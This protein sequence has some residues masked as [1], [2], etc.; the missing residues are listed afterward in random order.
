VRLTPAVAQRGIAVL[1]VL[2]LAVLIGLAI[3]SRRGGSS[4]P[5][6]LPARVGD[7]YQARAAPLS[8]DLEG[9]TTAC[10][11]QLT[12]RSMGIA[13]P[14]LPC[15]AKI[16]VGYRDEDVLTQVIATG[17]GPAGTRF[18]LTPALARSL[19]IERPVTIRWSYAR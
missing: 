19:G 1:A 18:G 7:W 11:V 17:P 13:D 5:S 16:F 10:G 8:D 2:L 3:A 15:G 12:G 6:E 9:T 14:V 4:S